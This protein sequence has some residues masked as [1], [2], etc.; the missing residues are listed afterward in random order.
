MEIPFE[1]KG[2]A[3][4]LRSKAEFLLGWEK[5]TKSRKKT[6]QCKVI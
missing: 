1:I 5:I 3:G 2:V 4:G 6:R